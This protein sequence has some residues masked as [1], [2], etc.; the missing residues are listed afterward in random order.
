M[1]VQRPRILVSSTTNVAVDRI[2]LALL[3]LGFDKFIRVGSARKIS[4]GILPY[5]THEGTSDKQEK[6]E[7][8]DMLKENL[9]VEE[10]RCVAESLRKLTENKS[11]LKDAPVVGATCAATAFGS[12]D[13]AAF[14]LV[15][16][17]EACQMTEPSS[18]LPVARFGCRK[19]VLVG[20]PK[21]LR[22]TVTG[23]ESAHPRGLEQSLFERLALQGVA[24]IMLREQYRCHP[25]ISAVSNSLFYDAHLVDGVTAAQRPA[26]VPCLPPLCFVDVPEGRAHRADDGSYGNKAEAAIVCALVRHLLRAGVAATDVGVIT[27]YRCQ[28]ALLRQLVA[29][30]F[31]QEYGVVQVSTVDAFQ[32]GEKAVVLLSCVLSDGSSFLSSP[33]RTNVAL[34]RAKN[35]MLIVGALPGPLGRGR[36]AGR[37]RVRV[38]THL[39]PLLSPWAR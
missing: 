1:D 34:S 8:E 9:S 33:E 28:A 4:K 25:A 37:R 38:S 7:L 35:H 17:D 10:R 16:L 19:L 36:Q 2:L 24:P 12:V 29:D 18:L 30:K 6:K 26:L 20:D 32:G 14:P 22:P 23:P 15:L 5:S 27:L 11:R 13:G 3:D 39:S 21:Q 31:G